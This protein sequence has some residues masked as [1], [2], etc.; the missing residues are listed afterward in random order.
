[1]RVKSYTVTLRPKLSDRESGVGI[2]LGKWHGEV[3][4]HY[5]LRHCLR[6][7]ATH[8]ML[9]EHKGPRQNVV[10]IQDWSTRPLA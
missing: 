2:V 6:H 4:C 7:L 1:M 10:L 5:F 8:S 9:G 3:G